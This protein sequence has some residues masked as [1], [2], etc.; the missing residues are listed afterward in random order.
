MG[1]LVGIA[2][3]FVETAA[4][5]FIWKKW[6][7]QIAKKKLVYGGAVAF[8]ILLSVLLFQTEY[9]VIEY[10][11][12]VVIYTIVLVLAGIDYQCKVLPNKILLAG[13]LIR[14]GLYILEAVLSPETIKNSLLAAAAG[15][16]FGFLFLLPLSILT[17]HGIGYGDVKLFVWLGYSLGLRDVY[18]IL[19]YSTLAAAIVGL[20]LMLV[21]KTDKKKEIPFAPA[22]LAG[23]Y[24]V[25]C[26]SFLQ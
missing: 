1:I 10:I 20:Y 7:L 12:F 14:T 17:K 3:G 5:I 13:A 16:L 2:A 21:K 18:S 6:G 25:F 15:F 4:V 11:N 19:F 23:T 26:M 24:L 9:V 8:S 22:V